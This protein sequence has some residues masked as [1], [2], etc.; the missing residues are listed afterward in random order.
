MIA[1]RLR[2]VEVASFD[3]ARFEV[4]VLPPAREDVLDAPWTERCEGCE[5]CGTLAHRVTPAVGVCDVCWGT[6]RALFAFVVGTS[7][8]L[9][10]PPDVAASY[11]HDVLE[12]DRPRAD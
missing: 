2:V 4:L 1:D 10:V 11:V 6:G 7:L 5:G 8:A 12:L 9:F 3:P